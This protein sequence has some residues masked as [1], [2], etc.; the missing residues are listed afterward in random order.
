MN[1]ALFVIAIMGCG[2]GSLPCE[3]L[4][5]AETR[6]ESHEQC[7]AATEDALMRHG[8]DA[9]FPLVVAECRASGAPATRLMPAD[10]MLPEPDRR[11][12]AWD[13]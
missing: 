13:D 11:P 1:A 5:V 12:S 10:V 2:E 3:E 7:L 4:L 9:P 8:L 6:F